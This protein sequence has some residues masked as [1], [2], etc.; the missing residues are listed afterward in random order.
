MSYKPQRAGYYW[1]SIDD[2]LLDELVN[3]A[4]S[5]T[6]IATKLQRTQTA[7]KYRVMNKALSDVELPISGDKSNLEEISRKINI[8]LVEIS[9]FAEKKSRMAATS[10]CK[11][12]GKLPQTMEEATAQ[13]TIISLTEEVARLREENQR[14]SQSMEKLELDVQLIKS[15][16]LSDRQ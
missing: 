15:L 16:L 6:E 7:V 3:K 11:E 13:S 14:L 12:V 9:A 5:W 10:V 2:A 4:T 1:S 8:P